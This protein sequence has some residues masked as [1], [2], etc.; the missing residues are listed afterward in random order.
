M[1][2]KA[3]INSACEKAIYA[4]AAGDKGALA[5]IYD[6]M[7][8]QIYSA[9]WSVLNNHSDAEDALQNTLCEI[10]RCAPNYKGGNA[11]SWILAIARNQSLNIIRKRRNESPADIAFESE[12][13]D[14]ESEFI[15]LEALSRLNENEREAVMLKIYCRCKHKEIAE[16]LGISV[17]AAEKLYQR[18]I[19]KLKKYYK[20][21]TPDEKL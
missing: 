6:K 12:K 20:E 10:L 8:R 13:G 9:A 7:S 4:I 18:G 5:V 2:E 15:Y 21:D 11:R 1:F 3:F 16:I 14:I 19:E 17:S